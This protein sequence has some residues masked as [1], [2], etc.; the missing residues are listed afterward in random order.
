MRIAVA[1]FTPARFGRDIPL[2]DAEVKAY[3]EGNSE[4]YRTEEQRLVSRIVLPY[5]PQ[6][7]DAV[8]KKASDALVEA[9]KGRPQFEAAA[10]KL[11]ARK[12]GEEWVTRKEAGPELAGVLFSA[13]ADTIV[14]PVDVK[15]TFVLAHVSR[16]RFPETLPLAQVRDRVVEQLRQ[17]KGKDLATIKAYEA[18]PK[19]VSGK[20]LAKTAAEYGVKVSET[21]WVGAEGSPE[22]PPVVAQDA[23][24][25]PAGEV[26]P[27]KTLGDS[28]YLSRCWRRRNPGSRRSEKSAARSP[29][30]PP[31]TGGSRRLAPRSSRRSSASKTAAELEANARKAGLVRRPD[32]LVRPARRHAPRGAGR[33]EGRQE[34]PR[35]ALP[36]SAGIPE[37][38]LRRRRTVHRRRV[39]RGTARRRRGLGGK[40]GLL[41][42]RHTGTGQE[43][44]DPGVP[45]GPHEGLEG[46]NPSGS[47]QVAR[48]AALSPRGNPLP[49]AAPRRGTLAAET[50]VV[51]EVPDGDTLR[52]VIDGARAT[53]RLIG[54]DAPERN[55]PTVGKEYYGDESAAFLSS[56]CLGKTVPWKR[57]RR[58]ST[59]TTASSGM[60]SLPRPT[61]AC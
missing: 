28:H 48:H 61:A 20:S 6:N 16:I 34:G 11:S 14:G 9:T 55:H 5:T 13:P 50:G 58:M 31:A 4:R 1:S 36:E 25:I 30:W 23:L 24:M 17:E 60:P 33:R 57:E 47:D 12:T 59:G 3:Y 53:V 2:S 37:D 39:P 43:R 52:V 18:H 44:A 38:L 29:P 40:E 7:R 26:G 51:E 45:L 27:V 41:P 10:K 15:G 19:A 56:L 32:R 22:V 49:P 21:G 42:R 35:P 54:I 8:R 46:R